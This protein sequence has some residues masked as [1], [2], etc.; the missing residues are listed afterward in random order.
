MLVVDRRE[1]TLLARFP[2]AEELR[3]YCDANQWTLISHRD[4]FGWARD[5]GGTGLKQPIEVERMK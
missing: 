2:N 5:N 3:R 4:G 1:P